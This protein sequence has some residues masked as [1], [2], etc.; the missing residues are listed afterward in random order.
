MSKVVVDL[1]NEVFLNAVNEIP[2]KSKIFTGDH[3]IYADALTGQLLLNDLK[4]QLLNVIE[5]IGLPTKQETAI[6]RLITNA[7]HETHHEISECL[8]LVRADNDC[9]TCV[10]THQGT[11]ETSQICA[12]CKIVSRGYQK[13]EY[14]TGGCNCTED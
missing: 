13:Y 3:I 9:S 8:E 14:Y 4:S 11:P 10:R 7:L 5:G 12:D 2:E 1:E 6:K